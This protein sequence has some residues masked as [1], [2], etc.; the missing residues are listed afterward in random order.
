MKQQAPAQKACL[1]WRSQDRQTQFVR[2]ERMD[3]DE[4]EIL[5]FLM[6][7]AAALDRPIIGRWYLNTIKATS[8]SHTAMPLNS[9]QMPL[10]LSSQPRRKAHNGQEECN[11]YTES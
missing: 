10:R 4:N 8:A 5:S 9:A 3:G 2:R 1:S 7:T 6:Y 11:N